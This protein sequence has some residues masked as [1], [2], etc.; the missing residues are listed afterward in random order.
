MKIRVLTEQ[1]KAINECKQFFKENERD[2]NE[3][4]YT[5]YSINWFS[6]NEF[7][8]DCKEVYKLTYFY[9]KIN[10]KNNDLDN[11]I[12]FLLNTNFLNLDDNSM[13]Y[14]L[15]SVYYS[16]VNAL[17]EWLENMVLLDF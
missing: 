6:E 12:V 2:L 13:G 15:R 3:W 1:Q 14:A 8:N 4:R 17:I 11:A 9:E 7:E 10:I 16:S 5:H